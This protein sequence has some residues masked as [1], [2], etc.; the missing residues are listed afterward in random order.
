MKLSDKHLLDEMMYVRAQLE[1]DRKWVQELQHKEV[2]VEGGHELQLRLIGSD[3]EQRLSIAKTSPVLTLNALSKLIHE[4]LAW[5]SDAL[6]E[7]GVDP[8]Q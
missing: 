5:N 6:R 2:L 7:I 8:D 4:A 1:A 3:R